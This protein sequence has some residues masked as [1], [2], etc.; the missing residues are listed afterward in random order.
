M[1]HP[2]NKQ[3]QRKNLNSQVVQPNDDN[4][5]GIDERAKCCMLWTKYW[6][7]DISNCAMSTQINSPN[8]IEQLFKLKTDILSLSVKSTYII[9]MQYAQCF[10]L[11]TKVCLLILFQI[12]LTEY[13]LQTFISAWFLLNYSLYLYK[14]HSQIKFYILKLRSIVIKKSIIQVFFSLNELCNRCPVALHCPG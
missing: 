5:N 4:K 14:L 10:A 9:Y 12:T 2:L 7:C 13:E 3:N 6:K 8:R 1:Q 11:S